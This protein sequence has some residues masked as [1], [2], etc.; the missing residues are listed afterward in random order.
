[1]DGI[2]ERGAV[3]LVHVKA[4]RRQ[5]G[6]ARRGRERVPRMR[7][8]AGLRRSVTRKC[9]FAGPVRA[10][11]VIASSRAPEMIQG[12]H[13][14]YDQRPP[15]PGCRHEPGGPQPWGRPAKSDTLTGPGRYAL[16]PNWGLA[17][18][19]T[20]PPAYSAPKKPARDRAAKRSALC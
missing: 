4:V 9:F 11:H 16:R 5:R 19:L 7:R 13:L 14:A 1:L 3:R 15:V 2:G 12:L 20:T 18:A 8:V 17:P 6:R 10:Y